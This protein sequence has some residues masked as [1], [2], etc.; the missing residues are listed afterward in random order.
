LRCVRR[1]PLQ[2]LAWLA[3]FALTVWVVGAPLWT[4]RYPAMTDLPFH[5]ASA[6]ILHHYFD[7]AWHFREQFAPQ[8]FAVP[9]LT[10]YAVAAV[11]MFFV[12]AV[13]AIKI[14]CAVM[15]GLLPLGLAVLS[16]AMGK[17]PL[18]GL[19]GVT[20]VWCGLTTW[21]FVNF[22]GAL[23]LFAMAT[24]LAILQLRRP[25]RRRG[26][27][28]A[29][30]LLAIFFT[31]PFRFPFAICAV[32]G[33]AMLL[34]PVSRRWRRLILPTLVP[35]AVF[36]IWW[37]VRPKAIHMTMHN[38]FGLDLERL[39]YV[40]AYIFDTLPGRRE[41]VLFDRMVRGLVG[42]VGV[43]GLAWVL[44]RRDQ[45]IPRRKLLWGIGTHGVVLGCVL[46]FLLAYL[47]LPMAIGNWWYVYPRE[48]TS[49]LYL[50][51]A[52]VPDLPRGGLWR[53][54]FVAWIGLLVVPIVQLHVDAQKTFDEATRDFTAILE[55]I[56]QA[57]RLLYLVIDHDP[58]PTQ[59]AL[60]IH[61]PAYVQALKGGWLSFHF[62][63]FG[64]TPMRYRRDEPDAVTPPP[65][66]SRW[67]WTPEVFDVREHGP[68]FD[69]FLIRK[70]SSPGY[71]LRADPSLRLVAREGTWW[72]F[73]REAPRM[74]RRPLPK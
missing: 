67:E 32:V 60:W 10:S 64:A 41:G 47:V 30:T 54:A 1:R 74:E 28:L 11:A 25:R 8:L 52:L 48:A 44:P 62:A 24:G 37:L 63:N 72:L 73:H 55:H 71:L 3:A 51:L 7:E 49:A 13:V 6:S 38:S 9:Y 42:L 21:G 20:L 35:L 57:P 5:A 26:V 50:A 12:D 27:A 39:D 2:A 40:K 59:R 34:G 58:A 31:H 36:G 46:A 61:L 53:L 18:L 19:L 14:A 45:P 68:F 65:V 66:P 15:L 56:P 23:G 17:T 4:G 70:R 43:L 69:W 16:R 29:L 33:V 22:M